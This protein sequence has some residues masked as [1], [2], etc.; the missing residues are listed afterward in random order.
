MRHER[1]I[2]SY[3]TKINQKAFKS[4]EQQLSVIKGKLQTKDNTRE[5][6]QI[7]PK[8]EEKLKLS[9]EDRNFLYTNVE[10]GRDNQGKLLFSGGLSNLTARQSKV[11]PLKE[12]LSEDA[13]DVKKVKRGLNELKNRLLSNPNLIPDLDKNP[14][15]QAMKSQHPETPLQA[16]TRLLNLCNSN[17]LDS[18]GY[19]QIVVLADKL[20]DFKKLSISAGNLKDVALELEDLERGIEL[21][22]KA[23]EILQEAGE[24]PEKA[25]VKLKTAR[26]NYQKAVNSLI[27]AN[28]EILAKTKALK[29]AE[30]NASTSI[31]RK[32]INYAISDLDKA[33]HAAG[34]AKN[35]AEARQKEVTAALKEI[36]TNISPDLIRREL[37]RNQQIIAQAQVS[38]EALGADQ[39]NELERAESQLEHYQNLEQVLLRYSARINNPITTDS[40]VVRQKEGNKVIEDFNRVKESLRTWGASFIN[41]DEIKSL[42]DIAEKMRNQGPNAPVKKSSGIDNP[43]LLE[44]METAA[45]L[46]EIDKISRGIEGL[47]SFQND[48]TN[49]MMLCYALAI[50]GALT[51]VLFPLVIY[52]LYNLKENL[53]NAK[54]IS[55]EL[56]SS[57]NNLP[58]IDEQTMNRLKP[59]VIGEEGEFDI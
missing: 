8:P 3:K 49:T 54:N 55:D 57:F 34:L 41:S 46:E 51:I 37:E 19:Q 25:S 43:T 23:R 52:W 32:M 28:D 44:V 11:D 5:I 14:E 16:V 22:N 30:A 15:W 2:V 24:I 35:T 47:E 9:N 33:K 38:K 48:N 1:S 31:G 40:E 42:R 59:I 58:S 10:G 36:A 21:S 26:E 20:E 18:S 4:Y 50:V 45:E 7:K 6:E 29:E 17:N 12:Q 56:K 13:K 39:L 53:E 27:Q